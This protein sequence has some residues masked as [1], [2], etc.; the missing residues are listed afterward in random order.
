MHKKQKKSDFAEFMKD[1][2][3]ILLRIIAFVLLISVSIIIIYETPNILEWNAATDGY[4]RVADNF[5]IADE[6]SST[7]AE[8][9]NDFVDT[10]PPIFV[11][12]F[13]RNWRVV[14]KDSIPV[15]VDYPDDVLVGGYTDW[16]SRTVVILRQEN[17]DDMLNIFTHELGHCFDLEY[18][19][20]SYSD[21][22]ND[23]YELYKGDFS[24]QSSNYLDGY[25]TSTNTEFFA[26][27]FNEY[28]LYPDHLKMA[29]PEAH[30][31]IDS[32]YEDVQ[33]IK[34]VYLYDLGTVANT[35]SRLADLCKGE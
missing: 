34:Y 13:Q 28:L 31:F 24:E 29:A 15:P 9:L 6:S 18:G 4:V 33:K 22:F 23:I 16:T 35:V 8:I 1:A 12:E 32:F 10:L 30:A 11:K 27:C 26:T 25:S 14:I 2:A 19:S 7:D 21:S 3:Y 5:H 20:V 17:V